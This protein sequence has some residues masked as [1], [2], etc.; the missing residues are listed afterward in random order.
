MPV[1]HA[2]VTR[3]A[4]AVRRRQE[5]RRDHDF[6]VSVLPVTGAWVPRF[7][8]SASCLKGIGKHH[9]HQG[10]HAAGEVD[11]RR[12]AAVAPNKALRY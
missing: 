11:W 4:G 10:A 6:A 9:D 7:G 1:R 5:R 3:L 8:G 12:A 2:D